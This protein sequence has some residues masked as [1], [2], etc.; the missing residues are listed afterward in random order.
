MSRTLGLRAVALLASAGALCQKTRPGLM[1]LAAVLLAACG[2][3]GTKSD[4]P[5]KSAGVLR[6]GTEG[7]YAPFSY[8]DPATGEL[9]GYDVDVARAVGEKIGVNV[10]FVETPWDS[11]FAALEPTGST[12]SRMRSRSRRSGKKS[13]TYPSRIRLVRA[14]SSRAPMTTL[15]S[16]W[17]TLKGKV[18][19]ETLTSNWAGRPRRRR[20]GGGRRRLHPGDH[21]AEPGPRRRGRQRQHRG[22]CLPGRE[23]RQVRQDRRA[24]RREE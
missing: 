6:V 17:P 15:S 13:T 16:L 19:G 14:S 2:S 11:I 4:N 7:V 20:T 22:L 21:A 5:L 18:A 8:H 23:K 3:S 12:W 10:E 9:T 1:L 24:G